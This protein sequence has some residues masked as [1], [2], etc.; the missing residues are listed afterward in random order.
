MYQTKGG[1]KFV[2]INDMVIDTGCV[3]P[4]VFS[5]KSIKQTLTNCVYGI[6]L[7]RGIG[8]IE[9][10]IIVIDGLALSLMGCDGR[11]ESVP[12]PLSVNLDTDLLVMLVSQD[13]APEIVSLNDNTVHLYGFIGEHL[14]A[15][16]AR[17]PATLSKLGMYG[18]VKAPAEFKYAG[19][20]GKALLDHYV[21]FSN[22]HGS[23]GIRFASRNCKVKL[24][25]QHGQQI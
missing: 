1:D 6:D 2:C 14:S 13:S 8:M 11:A 15:I 12:M 21:Y 10:P 22:G 18:V 23:G 19:L 3:I 24:F 16:K 5:H 7:M 4:Q 9:S 20:I 17:D 25:D